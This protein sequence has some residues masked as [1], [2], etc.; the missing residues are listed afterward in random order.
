MRVSTPYQFDSYSQGIQ[1]AHSRLLRV[2]NQVTTGKRIEKFS[3]DPLGASMTVSMRSLKAASG[4]YQSNLKLAKGAVGF[5]EDAL[6]NIHELARKAYELSVQGANDTTTQTS[7]NAM[8][9]EVR[10]LKRRLVDLG[11]TRGP[12]NQYLFAGTATDVMPYKASGDTIQFEGNTNSVI[13]EVGPNTTLRQ[14]TDGE[15]M[16]SDLFQKLSA[17]ENNLLGGNL[18]AISGVDIA[19][20]QESMNTILQARSVVGTKLQQ[21]EELDA[22]HT[23]RIDELSER[24]SDVEDIDMSEAVVKLKESE[25]AYQAALQVAAQGYSMSLMDFIRG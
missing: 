9:S 20:I 19:E 3:D 7:R 2:Q 12:Q 15:P 18:G 21:I 4:Q 16:I 6:S 14:N 8:A 23:R 5:T 11:N 22:H 1:S 13:A 17:L 24:I 25:I 10:D